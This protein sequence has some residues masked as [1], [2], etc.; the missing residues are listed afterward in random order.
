[1]ILE[2]S[3]IHEYANPVPTLSSCVSMCPPEMG[4]NCLLGIPSRRPQENTPFSM[5]AP[6][7]ELIGT[8]ES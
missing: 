2:L 3:F 1:M 5:R 4:N 7:P 8:K 6:F